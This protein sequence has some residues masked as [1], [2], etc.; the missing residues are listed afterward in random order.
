LDAAGPNP[1]A[2]TTG[3]AAAAAAAG[4]PLILNIIFFLGFTEPSEDDDHA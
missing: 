1:D 3:A 2:T 4:A